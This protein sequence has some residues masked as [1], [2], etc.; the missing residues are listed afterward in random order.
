[1]RARGEMRDAKIR[2]VITASLAT[3]LQVV[4]AMPAYNGYS[5]TTPTKTALMAS[6]HHIRQSVRVTL[7]YR[8]LLNPPY[9]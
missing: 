9:G 5:A 7:E 4:P 3:Q 1:M 8:W 6:R 2:T